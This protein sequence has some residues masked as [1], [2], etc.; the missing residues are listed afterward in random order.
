MLKADA[1]TATTAAAVTPAI[2]IVFSMLDAVFADFNIH[3]PL[4]SSQDISL[5]SGQV[6]AF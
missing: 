4:F 5:Q 3:K 6:S 2:L 1:V